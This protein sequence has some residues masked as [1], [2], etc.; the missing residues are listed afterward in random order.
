[1]IYT[2]L[3][4]MVIPSM[5]LCIKLYFPGTALY[6]D[7]DG[8]TK[9]L[10]SSQVLTIILTSSKFYKSILFMRNVQIKLIRRITIYM[11]TDLSF[12][13]GIRNKTRLHH[14]FSSCSQDGSSNKSVKTFS[15]N[16]R[17]DNSPSPLKVLKFILSADKFFV[18]L[19]IVYCLKYVSFR[20]VKI[21]LSVT[22]RIKTNLWP[23]HFIK[24]NSTNL[25]RCLSNWFFIMD[26]II[27][28]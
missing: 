23:E 13:H 26:T 6:G 16:S 19:K 28:D 5:T 12:V 22:Q 17:F 20:W 8:E 9:G 1:M 10:N 2:V 4:L 25:E 24:K 21:L 11:G 7:E 14:A 27:T 15:S 3:T 18:N